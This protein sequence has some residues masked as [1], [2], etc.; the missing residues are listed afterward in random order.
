MLLHEHHLSGLC[1]IT[2]FDAIQVHTARQ[3]GC[4]EAH[5][6]G[7]GRLAGVYERGD[8]LPG[9]VVHLELHV[10]GFRQCVADACARVEW[11]RVVLAQ[12]EGLWEVAGAVDAVAIIT[13]DRA[14]GKFEWQILAVVVHQLCFADGE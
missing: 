8:A 4:V 9:D 14:V 1:E 6:V 7:T 13:I 11:V 10:R 3:V 12:V 2:R 5:F